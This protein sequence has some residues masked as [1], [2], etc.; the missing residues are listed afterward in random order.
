M[1]H[2]LSSFSRLKRGSSFATTESELR[3][4]NYE[5]RPIPELEAK[6]LRA[7]NSGKVGGRTQTRGYSHRAADRMFAIG[8]SGPQF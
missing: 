2:A 3:L 8:Q 5:N 7:E 6:A 4:R 1:R